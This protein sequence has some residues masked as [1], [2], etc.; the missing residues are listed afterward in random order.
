MSVI[1]LPKILENTLGTILSEMTVSSWNIKGSE[2]STQVWIRFITQ[3]TETSLDK[4]NIT[5]R[6]VPPVK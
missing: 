5:Y 2:D 1:G 6:K 3:D 4:T